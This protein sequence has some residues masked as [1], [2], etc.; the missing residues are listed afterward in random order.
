MSSYSSGN[1][2]FQQFKEVLEQLQ[3]DI[4]DSDVAKMFRDTWMLGN[5][6]V[7]YDSFILA[8]NEGNFFLKCMLLRG[9][10]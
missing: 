10:H 3:P 1:F 5:G 6:K 8:A 2:T 9:N 4:S 7:N